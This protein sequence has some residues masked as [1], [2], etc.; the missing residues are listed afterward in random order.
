MFEANAERQE[1][2]SAMADE[3]PLARVETTTERLERLERVVLSLQ[4]TKT[5]EERIANRVSNSLAAKV[6][7]LPTM[8]PSAL[9]SAFIPQAIAESESPGNGST[10]Y[11]NRF[12]WLREFR[13]ILG[14]FLD[15]RYQLSR[16]AQYCIPLL[17]LSMMLLYVMFNWIIAIP[18]LPIIGVILERLGLVILAIALYKVLSR[19]AERYDTVLTYLARYGQR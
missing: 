4:D 16:F 14:M 15:S 9:I 6:S 10:F 13:L 18:L 3:I 19:E 1:H 12:N 2:S 8:K 5:L 11:I 7:T 17:L